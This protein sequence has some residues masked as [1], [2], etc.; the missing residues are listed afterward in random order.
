MRQ[1]DPIFFTP[2]SGPTN[3]PR[4]LHKGGGKGGD[5][6]AAARKAAED[7]RIADAVKKLNQVFA[8]GQFDPE[9]VDINRFYQ[10]VPGQ[11]EYNAIFPW[12]SNTRTSPVNVPDGFELQT[13]QNQNSNPMLG[14][15]WFGNGYNTT[16]QRLFNRRG[17]DEAV[18]KAKAAADEKNRNAMANREGIYTKIGQDFTNNAMVDLE[19]DYESAAREQRFTLARAGLSGGSRDI[20]SNRELTDRRNQGVLRATNLGIQAANNAR[21]ADDKTRTDLISS[22]YAGLTA[23][24]AVQQASERMR[25]NARA[26]SDEAGL[27]SLG[28]FFDAIKQQQ[29]MAAYQQGYNAFPQ[30]MAQ[31]GRVNTAQRDFNGRVGQA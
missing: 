20:D 18:G 9:P 17:Y 22:I 11:Q 31:P 10:D 19:K 16:S 30:P 5:G 24:N 23:D 8:V 28:G 13:I 21:S 1:F 27:A 26:A 29:Q 25:N 4:T 12:L 3:R 2:P 7:A 6:G 14:I 15:G